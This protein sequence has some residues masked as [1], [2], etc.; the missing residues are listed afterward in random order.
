MKNYIQEFNAELDDF[1]TIKVVYNRHFKQYL[2]QGVWVSEINNSFFQDRLDT[3]EKL[4][5]NHLKHGINNDIFLLE[6]IE[7]IKK[8][9]DLL[10]DHDYSEFSF[11]ENSGI[12]IRKTS[13]ISNPPKKEEYDY[14]YFVSNKHKA[15]RLNDNFFDQEQDIISYHNHLSDL[16]RNSK[17]HPSEDEFEQEKLL[18][19][20][21]TY[22][23][24]VDDLLHKI[25]LLESNCDKI[26]FSTIK[27]DD[28]NSQINTNINK[29]N[30]NISKLKL[31]EFINFLM[32]EKYI[33]FNA[34][35]E[36]KNKI[37][38][39]EFFQNNFT[40]KS[41]NTKQENIK[42]LNREISES[43]L[44]IK[45]N[46]NNYIDRLIKLLESKKKV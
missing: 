43:H 4:L 18:R 30:L 25:A 8:V 16:F 44:N 2:F 14:N 35:S 45:E 21:I 41:P 37:L 26:N 20:I 6:T 33:N 27:I 5:F 13:N 29:C 23:G 31:A 40:Y 38:I 9:D 24:Y 1:L 32:I 34:E 3:L 17:H 46:Y 19:V 22:V 12:S 42:S 15:K 10:Y 28:I 11:F 36:A 39:Q 7:K